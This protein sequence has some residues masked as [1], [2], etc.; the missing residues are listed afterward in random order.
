M[1]LKKNKLII[2]PIINAINDP[3]KIDDI[4]AI[5]FLVVTPYKAIPANKKAVVKN[6]VANVPIGVT[7]PI[8]VN[9]KPFST[10]N[11]INIPN[12]WAGFW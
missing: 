12:A 6:A 11:P 7:I 4:D 1:L 5:D 10:A 2:P 8:T 3:N 9:I